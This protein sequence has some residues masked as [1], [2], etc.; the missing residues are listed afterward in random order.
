V[1]CDQPVGWNG[2]FGVSLDDLERLIEAVAA[3]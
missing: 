3:R 1:A 2:E